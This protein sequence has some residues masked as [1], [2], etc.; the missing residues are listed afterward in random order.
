VC[1]G[2]WRALGIERCGTCV[3]VMM[4][5]T[6][7]VC[8]CPWTLGR[9]KRGRGM[10]VDA[11]S[12]RDMFGHHPLHLILSPAS[13]F[14]T[15]KHT[16]HR[17]F[18]NTRRRRAWTLCCW[19]L[20]LWLLPCFLNAVF[21]PLPAHLDHLDT[22]YAPPFFDGAL[23]IPT[24]RSYSHRDHTMMLAGCRSAGSSSSRRL[25]GRAGAQAGASVPSSLLHPHPSSSST[26]MASALGSRRH[27]SDKLFIRSTYTCV[28]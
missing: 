27:I 23:I 25:L 22:S 4:P 13:T 20:G 10:Q 2:L 18:I 17:N 26:S 9:G 19:W 21:P 28:V 8:V 15:Y 16:S 3:H 14:Y 6:G 24:L 1:H 11:A 7:S 12:L 5:C